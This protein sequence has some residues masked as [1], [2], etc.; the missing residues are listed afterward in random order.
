MK[1]HLNIQGVHRINKPLPKDKVAKVVF[2]EMAFSL[3]I[4]RGRIITLV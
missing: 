3:R 2:V 4:P 1:I